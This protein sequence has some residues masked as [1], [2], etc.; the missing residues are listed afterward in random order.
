MKAT[1]QYFPVVLFIML[2]KVVRTFESVDEIFKYGIQLKGIETELLSC[3][4]VYYLII[5]N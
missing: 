3:G 1:E 2:Y 4:A 5:G